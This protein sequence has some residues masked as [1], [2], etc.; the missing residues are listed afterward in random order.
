M[1]GRTMEAPAAAGIVGQ[2]G[3]DAHGLDP[4]GP[5]HW[6]LPAAQLCEVAVARGE[7]RARGAWP[8][9]DPSWT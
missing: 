8:T 7:G 3:L 1:T 5:I 6:N 2:V 9:W 4:V